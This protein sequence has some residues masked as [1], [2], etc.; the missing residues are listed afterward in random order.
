[1]TTKPSTLA[2]R[3]AALSAAWLL[4][5]PAQAGLVSG[6]WDPAFGDA[7]FG[8]SWAVHAELRVPDNACTDLSG[9]Q[10]TTSGD[11]AGATLLGVFLRLYDSASGA[12]DWSNPAS[13]TS[14]LF[15]AA[16]YGVCDTSVALDP[17]YTSR[18]GAYF[19]NYF[20]LQALRIE[21]GSVVGLQADVL[22]PFVTQVSFGGPTLL[23]PTSAQGHDFSLA[24]TL[25]GPQLTCVTCPD[26]PVQSQLDGLRQFLVTYTS[27]DT[28]A[29]KFRDSAGNALGVLLDQD[30]NVLG[31]STSINGPLAVPEPGSLGLVA[32]ALAA[33]ALLRRRRV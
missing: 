12:P 27:N 5:A 25:N 13:Y 1:M 33:A 28:S 10:S 18:C 30:G 29:P 31:R 3:M 26:G 7:L 8:L 19:G 20:N 21:G 11:C 4:Q 14:S 16:A 2:L 15:D 23:L 24:F 6:S 32:A 9:P 22:A 17:A